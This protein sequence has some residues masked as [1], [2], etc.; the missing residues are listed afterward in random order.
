MSTFFFDFATQNVSLKCFATSIL[1]SS[2]SIL[3]KNSV[4]LLIIPFQAWFKISS[5]LFKRSNCQYVKYFLL[6]ATTSF[7]LYLSSFIHPIVQLN[8]SKFYPIIWAFPS[9][10]QIWHTDQYLLDSIYLYEQGRLSSFP[11][12]QIQFGQ[13]N[14]FQ[15]N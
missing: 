9:K 8:E 1:Q 7:F 11:L 12:F 6:I 3:G 14:V 4:F 15:W 10:R 13:K 5:G 2:L